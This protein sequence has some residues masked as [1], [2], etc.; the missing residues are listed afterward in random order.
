MFRELLC[1]SYTVVRTAY[2]QNKWR[3]SRAKKETTTRAT[4]NK[5]ELIFCFWGGLPI[6]NQVG[7]ALCAFTP[8]CWIFARVFSSDEHTIRFHDSGKVKFRNRRYDS[9]SVNLEKRE[10]STCLRQVIG[11][12][13][14]LYGENLA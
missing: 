11:Y 14:R 3:K 7:F 13:P 9:P 4:E 5:K 10:E 12:R 2:T 8:W 1:Q 6:A